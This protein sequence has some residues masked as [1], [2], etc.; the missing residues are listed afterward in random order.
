MDLVNLAVQAVDG[1]KVGA[2]AARDRTYDAEGLRRL[3]KRLEETIRELEAQNEGGE[4]AEPARLPKELA[5]KKGLRERVREAMDE[6]AG[7]EE[8]KRI[9]LTDAEAQFMKTHQGILLAYNAQA[10]ASPVELEGKVSG[11]LVTAVDVVEETNDVAGLIPMLEQAEETTDRKAE[12]TLADAGYHSGSNL[13]ECANRG[14]EVVM[15]ESQHKALKS[16]YH[17]DRFTYDKDTDS[18]KC[19]QGQR[20]GF[21][22][23]KYTRGVRMRLYRAPAAVCRRCPAFGVCTKDQ[24]HGR[25]LEIG[26]HDVFLRSHRAWMSTE[27]A[28]N[29]YKQRKQL[30]EPVFGI[31]KE[32][33]AGR[34]FLLRSRAKVTAEWTMLATAFN[35]RTLWRAWRTRTAPRWGGGYP[36][37]RLSTHRSM[38]A[39]IIRSALEIL[40]LLRNDLQSHSPSALALGPVQSNI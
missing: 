17:K 25:A 22:A 31:I 18:Y 2:N 13:E 28:R 32:Q 7:E 8:T 26:P 36:D 15:P 5:K 40:P 21:K 14:H 38:L 24:R 33:Q 30:V 6:L 23:M 39:G 11:M 9:N 1:T 35:L 16:P 27:E 37:S 4:D 19:P 20:L 12:T 10:M 3:L 29:K 34:R